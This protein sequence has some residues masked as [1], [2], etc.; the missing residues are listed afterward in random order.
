MIAWA[1][2][3]GRLAHASPRCRASMAALLEA[4]GE[5]LDATLA[6]ARFLWPD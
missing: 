5:P 2:A 4:P 1:K 3:L 6:L